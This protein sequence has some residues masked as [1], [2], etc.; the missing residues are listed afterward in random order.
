VPALAVFVLF[1]A[2]RAL[3]DS[4][5]IRLAGEWA[6]SGLTAVVGATERSLMFVGSGGGVYVLDIS[7][8]DTPQV[9]SM[10]IQTLGT[11]N[12]LFCGLTAQGLCR[13]GG[14]GMIRGSLST[15]FWTPNEEEK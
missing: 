2:G 6:F 7:N 10:Q 9:L 5:N 3:G 4:L 11:V 1:L 12:D 15:R 13:G 8:P 14:W